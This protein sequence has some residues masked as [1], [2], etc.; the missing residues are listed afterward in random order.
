MKLV[1]KKKNL[2]QLSNKNVIS[3][4]ETNKVFGAVNLVTNSNEAASNG[5]KGRGVDDYT[6]ITVMC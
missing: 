1:I 2:K 4:M 3:A 6:S 5:D